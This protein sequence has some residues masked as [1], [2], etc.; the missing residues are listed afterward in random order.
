MIAAPGGAGLRFITVVVVDVDGGE[1]G[2][3]L[4]GILVVPVSNL[5]GSSTF[6]ICIFDDGDCVA[7][8]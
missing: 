7:R 8:C 3:K 6:D 5:S 1:V 4:D 2:S